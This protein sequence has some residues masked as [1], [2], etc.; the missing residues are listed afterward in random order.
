[1][2]T[3]ETDKRG[4][5]Y[6]A[7]QRDAVFEIW[8]YKADR[9]FDQAALLISVDDSCIELG[10]N[11]V[12]ARTIRNWKEQF[13]WE[14]K[15]DTLLYEGARGRRYRAQTALVLAAPEAAE[16]L[17]QILN[18]DDRLMTEDVTFDKETGERTVVRVFNDKIIGAR[19]KAAMAVL[20]RTGFSPIGLRELGEIDT[21]PTAKSSLVA[22]I[23]KITDI[24]TLRELEA[25]A[26]GQSGIGV[27][28]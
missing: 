24:D 21:P 22:E 8:A 11:T 17:R 15:A 18:M 1:M 12:T 23:Q 13:N 19:L 4:N 10:V 3:K 6:N 25:V 26:R 2:E 14:E 5:R 28:S 27:R 9:S 7:E 20:D 16:V